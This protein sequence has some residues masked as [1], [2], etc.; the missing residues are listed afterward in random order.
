MRLSCLLL[1]CT[2]LGL[3]ACQTPSP[4]KVEDQGLAKVLQLPHRTPAYVA[5]DI[6]R[7]PAETLEFFDV[8]ASMSVG[9]IWPGGGWYSEIL[10][11][12]LRD[13][14]QYYAI[15]F[16]TK[17]ARTPQWRKDM[18]TQL[19]AKFAAYP[20]IYDKAVV[21]GLAVPDDVEIAPAQSLDRVLTFRNVHNWMKGGY[22]DGVFSA[23]FKALKPGGVLGVVEHRAAANTSYADMVK[24]GYVTEAEVIRLATQA[25]FVLQAKSEVNAN[26]KDSKDHPKGV[27][28]LPPSLRL[29]EQ[30]REYYQDI[31]ESDRMTLKFTRPS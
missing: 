6:Y 28:T 23:M 21:T 9:E 25:G 10:A 19:N 30:Q 22:A 17:A 20:H 31:G 13:T 3:S 27:W 26:T 1:L 18:V 16:S 4:A 11:P 8:Q 24:S 7:H 12:Y 14:G 29:G 15:G 5:R 2:L